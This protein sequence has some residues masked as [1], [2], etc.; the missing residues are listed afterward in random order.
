MKDTSAKIQVVLFAVIS[1]A[2]LAWL[3][4]GMIYQEFN[5]WLLL[6]AFIGIFVYVG[7]AS[8]AGIPSAQISNNR[9]SNSEN[10]SEHT[11]ECNGTGQCAFCRGTGKTGWAGTHSIGNYSC[12][13]CLG[14]GICHECRGTGNPSKF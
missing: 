7:Y 2:M 13:N 12:P 14:T 5:V 3:L 4:D 6:I 10:H 9:D 11:C 1:L 8:Y